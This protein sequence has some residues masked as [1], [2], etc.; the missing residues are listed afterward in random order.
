M[1][2]QPTCIPLCLLAICLSDWLPVCLP[3]S[4]HPCCSAFLP[5]CLP[6]CLPACLPPCV[7][8]SLSVSL[9]LCF[10]TSSYA[11]HF[12]LRLRLL[13]ISATVPSTRSGQCLSDPF[14]YRCL[15]VAPIGP[16]TFT[17]SVFGLSS[18]HRHREVP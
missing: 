10:P 8:A 9:P 6:V 13:L 18:T 12:R 14:A 15:S 17:A 1:H 5:V 3:V 4:L 2:M 16:T 11:C 7:F